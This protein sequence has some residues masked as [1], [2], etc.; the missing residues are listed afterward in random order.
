MQL[1]NK[2]NHDVADYFR[3]GLQT[4]STNISDSNM[5]F[6]YKH[7]FF[8]GLN[9][10]PF[11]S[12]E[13]ELVNFPINQDNVQEFYTT[14]HECTNSL[15]THMIPR[16]NT[17]FSNDL[18]EVEDALEDH[19]N[20][21]HISPD[22]LALVD[23]DTISVYNGTKESEHE[24]TSQSICTEVDN[25]EKNDHGVKMLHPMKQNVTAVSILDIVPLDVNYFS[26]FQVML[27]SK[28]EDVDTI[29]ELHEG[30]KYPST[31]FSFYSKINDKLYKYDRDFSSVLPMEYTKSY[32]VSLPR[33]FVERD[34][35]NESSGVTNSEAYL[36]S[37]RSP[38]IL[39]SKVSS[40]KKK[41]K[42]KLL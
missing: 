26:T 14:I 17:G 8:S 39:L 30:W 24:A 36:I 3:R 33:N 7:E 23:E 21:N 11:L 25:V 27:D 10:L 41:P 4:P 1:K 35:N 15:Q 5:P 13:P 19:L 38:K 9:K 20:K 6:P 37:T 40:V 34:K 29:L 16:H 18:V 42:I 31:R 22:D 32:I 12:S 28:D 2:V